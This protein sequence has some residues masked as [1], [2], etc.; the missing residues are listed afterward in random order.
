[1]QVK[2]KIYILEFPFTDK[3]IRVEILSDKET[4]TL[5]ISDLVDIKN[6]L[7]DKFRSLIKEA[8]KGK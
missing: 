1:M 8:E 4:N 5:K 2:S 7:N 6:E 3:I